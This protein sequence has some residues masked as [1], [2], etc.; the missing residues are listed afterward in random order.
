[1]REKGLIANKLFFLSANYNSEKGTLCQI[2]GS[3][4]VRIQCLSF[5]SGA[6]SIK[7]QHKHDITL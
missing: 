4:N 1:M 3:L 6:L 5:K 7:T 2:N